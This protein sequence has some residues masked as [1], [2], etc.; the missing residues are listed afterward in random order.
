MG[1]FTVNLYNLRPII[2]EVTSFYI[3]LETLEFGDSRKMK[4]SDLTLS[5]LMKCANEH[6]Q[7]CDHEFKSF[8][9]FLQ[10]HG[11]ILT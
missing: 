2:C 6:L 7:Y 5:V 8:P 10:S 3:L 4:D 1:P 11:R 9:H